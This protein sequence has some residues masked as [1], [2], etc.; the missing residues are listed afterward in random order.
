MYK[1]KR[2]TRGMEK[3]DASLAQLKERFRNDLLR[4]DKTKDSLCKDLHNIM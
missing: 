3:Y 2:V 1:K 4:H